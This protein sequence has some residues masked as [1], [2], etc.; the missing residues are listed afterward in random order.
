M[1]NNVLTYFCFGIRAGS[2]LIPSRDGQEDEINVRPRVDLCRLEYIAVC[3]RVL[4][5]IVCLFA[6]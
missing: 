6:A 2:G 4:C 5:D 3:E 1:F